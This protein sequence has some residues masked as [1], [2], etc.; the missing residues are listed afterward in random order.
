LKSNINAKIPVINVRFANSIVNILFLL[1]KE[2]LY[3]NKE[4][5]NNGAI[6]TN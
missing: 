3:K 2:D 5:I 1:F 4:I 6:N